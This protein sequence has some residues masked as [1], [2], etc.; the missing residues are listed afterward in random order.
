MMP[1]NSWCI[2][3]IVA[4]PRRI[5]ERFSSVPQK[6]CVRSFWPPTLPKQVSLSKTWHLSST[7]VVPKKKSYDP[8]LKTSTLQE[9]WISRASAKQRKGRAGRCKAGVCFHL[10][11]NLRH[12]SMRPF[13]ESELIRSPLEEICLL[14]KRLKFTLGGPDDPDGIPA[15]LSKAM[16]TPH[17]KSVTNALELL[18]DLGAMDEETNEL[19]DL[20]VCLSAMSLEPRVGKMVIMSHLIGCAKASSSMAVAMSYKSPFSIPPPSMRK[21]SDMAKLRLS[22]NS[23]SDQITSLNV[24]RNRDVLS[25]R[26]MGALSGWCRQNFMNFSAVNMISDLRKNVS[27]ELEGL[28]FPPSAQQGGY[29]NRNGDF[30]P[31]F[32]QA[33]IC[34]GLYPNVAYRRQ[35]DV[36]FTTMSNQ[37]AKVHMGSV[38]GVRSQP[39]SRKCEVRNNE[40]E[41]IVFGELVK[42]KAVFNMEHTTHLASPLPLLLL[43]GQLHIRPIQFAPPGESADAATSPVV[44]KAILSLDDWLVFLCEPNTA[45]ALVVLRQRLDSAFARITSD[46]YNFTDLPA[47][48]KDAVDTLSTVLNSSHTAAPRRIAQKR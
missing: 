44:Q 34:A 12:A 9:A 4:F 23:E 43:C 3:F 38:N 31:A 29:H 26:G 40:V 18:V 22:E 27:R 10:F 39:L 2:L 28:G 11:S 45:S 41:F 48:E 36:N 30:N 19:T 20:G 1:L 33:S 47:V 15:F 46:P 21:A 42:G 8:H 17:P 16:T 6:A 32:L 24:L 35:G 7:L 37:K 13:V 25:K 14:C 5:S